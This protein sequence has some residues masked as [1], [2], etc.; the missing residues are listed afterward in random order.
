M[1]PKVMRSYQGCVFPQGSTV[2]PRVIF[3]ERIQIALGLITIA[4]SANIS[5]YI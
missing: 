1:Q 4:S 3:P 5:A 2:V